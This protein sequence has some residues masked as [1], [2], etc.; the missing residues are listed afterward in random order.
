M[1]LVIVV[2]GHEVIDKDQR[3]ALPRPRRLFLRAY[4]ATLRLLA[5]QLDGD[6][7]TNP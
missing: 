3:L 7:S 2:L 5:V 1:N 4:E 6:N